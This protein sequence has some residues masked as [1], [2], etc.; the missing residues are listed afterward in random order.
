M[1]NCFIVRLPKTR[2]TNGHTNKMITAKV[3]TTVSE[4]ATQSC[5]KPSKCKAMARKPKPRPKPMPSKILA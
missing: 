1:K 3:S 4:G 5:T 2:M